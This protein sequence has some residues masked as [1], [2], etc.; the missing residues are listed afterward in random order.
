MTQKERNI[1]ETD[2]LIDI[3]LLEEQSKRKD[4]E[5]SGKFNPSSFGRCYRAQYWNRK[6]EPVSNPP[7]IKSLR[8][9]KQGIYTHRLNQDF[10]PKGTTEIKVETDDVLGF[11]DYV[12][13]D[14]VLDYKCTDFMKYENIPTPKYIEENPEKFLQCCFYAIELKKKYV[15][16]AP[17]RFGTFNV[18]KHIDLADNWKERLNNELTTLRMWWD[19]DLLPP[20]IPRCWGGKECIYCNWR[21][22]CVEVESGHRQNLNGNPKLEGEEV[23]RG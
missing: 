3:C 8:R 12:D 6:N 2:R 19:K 17:T 10:L 13:S 15:V 7:D 21:S 5:R 16:I 14:G 4:R 20:A 22:K 9:F 23:S 11:A 1:L 18:I